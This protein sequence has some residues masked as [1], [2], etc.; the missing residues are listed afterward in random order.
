MKH[1]ECKYR[2][3]ELIVSIIHECHPSLFVGFFFRKQ[4]MKY[5]IIISLFTMKRMFTTILLSVTKPTH[6]LSVKERTKVSS[7]RFL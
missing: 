6:P 7:T 4:M 5:G 3:Q 2:G 1:E